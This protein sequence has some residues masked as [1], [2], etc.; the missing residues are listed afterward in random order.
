MGKFTT[1]NI[2]NFR[3]LDFLDHFL[4][5]H[6]GFIAGGCFKNIFNNEKIKDV[7]IYFRNKVDF[8][9]AK[10]YFQEKMLESGEPRYKKSY[11]NS[12]VWAIM[13]VSTGIRMELIQSIYG[14]P[15]DVIDRFDFTIT[16]FAYWVDNTDPDNDEAVTKIL[17]C[18]DYF[19]HL[20]LKRLVIPHE[21]DK[22]MMPISTFN[23]SYKYKGYGFGLCKESKA[24]LIQSIQQLPPITDIDDLGMSLYHGID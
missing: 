18:K 20:H 19:E 5:G 13:D 12:N 10:T 4:R 3:Q 15:A 1:G 14:E 23:R 8:L 2:Q 16:Q 7:D 17:Y 6:K 22:I 9:E 11:E 21:P 24:K